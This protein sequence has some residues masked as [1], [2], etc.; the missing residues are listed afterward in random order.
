LVLLSGLDDL[1]AL[2]N[3]DRVKRELRAGFPL[4][5]YLLSGLQP[6][7]KTILFGDMI[8][9]ADVVVA[10]ESG[11][12]QQHLE[13]FTEAVD[14]TYGAVFASGRIVCATANWWGLHT[15]ELALLSCFILSDSPCSLSDTPVFLPVKSPTVPFRLISCRLTGEIQVSAL[16]GPQPSLPEIQ[17]II[18]KLWKPVQPVLQSLT[19]YIPRCIPP[20]IQLDRSILGIVLVNTVKKRILASLTP[21]HTQQSRES[22]SIPLSRRLD[23]M[24]TSYRSIV[25][26]ILQSSAEP[27]PHTA[28]LGGSLIP[29]YTPHTNLLHP[30]SETFVCSELHKCYAVQSGPYQLFS[31]FISAVP[32]H[33]IRRIAERTLQTLL[34]EKHNNIIR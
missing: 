33:S 20:Y 30:V 10:H 9:G 12:L 13:N 1:I 18:G 34:K 8:G 27:S 7:E 17:T 26:A 15:D 4:I 21:H 2:R 16:C 5:D 31:L 14:S 29:D 24:R 28:E 3:I 19:N 25:G 11:Q 23:I 22:R 32:N 6:S